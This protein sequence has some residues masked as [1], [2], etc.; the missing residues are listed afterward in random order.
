MTGLRRHEP[1]SLALTTGRDEQV[2]SADVAP[3]RPKTAPEW[4]PLVAW[5]ICLI[6]AICF[7]ISSHRL[8]LFDES[9]AATLGL[10]PFIGA[11]TSAIAAVGLMMTCQGERLET[12]SRSEVVRVCAGIVLLVLFVS[13]WT[14][15]G[16]VTATVV[17]TML[18]LK[19]LYRKS[20][21]SSLTTSVALAT[22]LYVIFVVLLPS[23]VPLESFL[24]R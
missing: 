6:G 8:G 21:L 12:W 24:P 17:A 10:W 19:L 3:A 14:Y 2:G 16:L 22:F 18:W 5:L 1:G 13:V 23:S 11:V 7:S 9:G 4:V 15:V 20:W